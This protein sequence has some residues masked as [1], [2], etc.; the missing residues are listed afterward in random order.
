MFRRLVVM[1]VMAMVIA[2]AGVAYDGGIA[3]ADEP[4]PPFNTPEGELEDIRQSALD[5]GSY[6]EG[7]LFVDSGGSA[8]GATGASSVAQGGTPNPWVAPYER[9]T[10]TNRTIILDGDMYKAKPR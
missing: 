10:P 5:N 6:G 7:V 1:L 4:V 9:M 3:S 8:A 2:M